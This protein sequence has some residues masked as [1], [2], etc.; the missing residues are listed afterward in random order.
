MS[1]TFEFVLVHFVLQHGP[2][3]VTVSPNHIIIFKIIGLGLEGKV[4]I[5][6]RLS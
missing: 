2:V 1:R 5:L 3:L 6:V 4:L